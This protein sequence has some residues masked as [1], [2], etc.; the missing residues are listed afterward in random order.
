VLLQKRADAKDSFPGCFDTS[1]AGHIK[2]GDEPLPSA[3]RELQEELG[4]TAAPN[5]LKP[6]GT[7]P[8]AYER[9]FHG[10]IFRDNEV[11]FVYVYTEPVQEQ[12]LKLQEEEVSAV[13]WFD[14]EDLDRALHPRDPL[15]CVPVEGFELVKRWLSSQS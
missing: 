8:I 13:Q 3:I 1:S 10:K 9:T 15:F 12:D 11:S 2:A 4:I 6:I 7:F 5:Q 14:V